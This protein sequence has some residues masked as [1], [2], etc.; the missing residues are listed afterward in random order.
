MPIEV[1]AKI[2]PKNN[3]FVTVVESVHTGVDT[4]GF[5]GLLTVADNTVQKALDRIDEIDTGILSNFATTIPSSLT[6]YNAISASNVTVT[7]P[8]AV[9]GQA[10]SI[11]NDALNTVTEV[12]TGTLSNAATSIPSSQTVFNA[13]GSFG[14][15]DESGMQVTINTAT[16]LFVWGGQRRI[17]N[18]IYK[19]DSQITYGTGT[20]ATDTLYYLYV[21]T[22]VS[23]YILADTELN[24]STTGCTY[25]HAK[26][27]YYMTG[28][29]TK[30]WLA[31]VKTA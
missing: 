1:I 6:V 25:D 13:I 21:N 11:V 26:G 15:G 30:R 16:S 5:A 31:N 7:A 22:P 3:A 19:A 23:G 8:L 4:S 12:D 29:G 18:A 2:E 9:S 24:I 10:L 17:N 28:D 27:A 14:G 20:L